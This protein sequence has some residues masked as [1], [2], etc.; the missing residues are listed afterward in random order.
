MFFVEFI[1]RDLFSRSEATVDY[2]SGIGV[3]FFSRVSQWLVYFKDTIISNF[4]V[5]RV[6][7]PC[8]LSVVCD[9][10]WAFPSG[11]LFHFLASTWFKSQHCALEV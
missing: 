8:R 4:I 2:S 10:L 6:S 9:S 5:G 3:Y 11:F 7:L 1:G